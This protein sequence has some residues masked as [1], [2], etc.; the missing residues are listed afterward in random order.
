MLKRAYERPDPTKVERR[1]YHRRS[2]LL[3]APKLNRAAQG[4]AA[5]DGSHLAPFSPGMVGFRAVDLGT[6]VDAISHAGDAI[7]ARTLQERYLD[8]A[9]VEAAITA[10]RQ[11]RTKPP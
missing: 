2:F 5:R 7:Y 3:V 9:C 10:S 1:V 11:G 8:F 6:V 4:T